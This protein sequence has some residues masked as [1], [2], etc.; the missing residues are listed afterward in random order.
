VAVDYPRAMAAYK[1]GAEGG[2]AVCQYQ[3]GMMHFFGQ[4]VDV[5]YKQALPWIEKAAAQDHPTAVGQLG[6]MYCN[7]LGV[8]PSWRRAREDYERAI[9]LGNTKSVKDMQIL[10]GN[11]QTVTSERS[12]H[13]A[14]SRTP[15]TSDATA[16]HLPSFLH[17]YRS[18]PSWTS[19][20]SSTARAGRT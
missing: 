17:A 2:D 12:H 9:K 5:D 15:P 14:T 7:G 6:S 1:V 10:T 19:G 11:I 18:P 3:V 13:P 4:G 8:T 16:T 20:W